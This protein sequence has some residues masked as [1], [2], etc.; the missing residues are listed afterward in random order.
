M[1]H[2][3]VLIL[4][5]A[6]VVL[7]GLWMF[8]ASAGSLEPSAPPAPTMHSLE[9]I[10]TNAA[11]VIKPPE[12]LGR[13]RGPAFLHLEGIP[14]EVTEEN[15]R[16]WI[17]VFDISYGIELSGDVGTGGGG[18]SPTA[19]FSPIVLTKDLDKASPLLAQKCA[20][21]RTIPD[22]TIECMQSMGGRTVYFRIDLSDV[23]ISQ[24][25]PRMRARQSGDFV[26]VEEIALVFSRVQWQYTQT[27]P[28]GEPAGTVEG[29]WD[30]V[31]NRPL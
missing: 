10:Y 2:K 20:E 4:G 17:A 24:V 29:G 13:S 6:T 8:S 11:G 22:A 21:G 18:G 1:S 7:V 19:T 16:D 23:R 3:S 5:L 14:G 28:T 9:D 25:A 12:V 30:V 27:G 15:H 31:A 26:F